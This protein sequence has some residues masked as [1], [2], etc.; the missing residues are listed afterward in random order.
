MITIFAD[1]H[2]F[3]ATK[4]RFSYKNDIMIL[5][6]HKLAVLYIKNGNVLAIFWQ[7]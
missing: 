3:W 6:L 1:F 5:F 4:W 7:K 2:H